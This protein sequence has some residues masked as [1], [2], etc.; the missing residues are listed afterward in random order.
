MPD[1]DGDTLG[2]ATLR[3]AVSVGHVDSF[4]VPGLYQLDSGLLLPAL[5]LGSD[6]VLLAPVLDACHLLDSRNCE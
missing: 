1:S 4:T 3:T 6:G 2:L 5:R